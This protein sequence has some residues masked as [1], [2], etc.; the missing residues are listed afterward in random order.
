MAMPINGLE[1][2]STHTLDIASSVVDRLID[3]QNS[4]SYRYRSASGDI[5]E[6]VR[7]LRPETF[8]PIQGLYRYMLNALKIAGRSGVNKRN[9][10]ILS[11]GKIIT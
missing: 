4:N 7:I 3:L 6:F 9:I 5:E 10:P 11:N 8:V 2:Y 1:V